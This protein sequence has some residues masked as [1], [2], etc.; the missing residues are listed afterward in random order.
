MHLA[1]AWVSGRVGVGGPQSDCQIVRRAAQAVTGLGIRQ[2]PLINRPAHVHVHSCRLFR[3]SKEQDDQNPVICSLAPPANRAR[4]TE[5]RRGET[6]NN[7]TSGKRTLAAS[8]TT[9]GGYR[10][11]AQ[12]AQLMNRDFSARWPEILRQWSGDFAVDNL[13]W[14]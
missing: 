1:A 3:Q 12:V 2:A 13:D 6:C 4:R 10:R 9:L 8:S 11:G 7:N 14:C 5:M